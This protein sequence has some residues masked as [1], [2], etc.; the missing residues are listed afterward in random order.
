MIKIHKCGK[1]HLMRSGCTEPMLCI[2]NFYISDRLGSLVGNPVLV[3][4]YMDHLIDYTLNLPIVKP[5]Q[6]DGEL[7]RGAIKDSHKF[8]SFYRK[9]ASDPVRYL[10]YSD[11]IILQ[12]P[13]P[14]PL[15][16]GP[17][18]Q[19]KP[20]VI[21]TRHLDKEPT[22]IPLLSQ[23]KSTLRNNHLG[24]GSRFFT[25]LHRRLKAV[26]LFMHEIAT[27]CPRCERNTR[28]QGA[29]YENQ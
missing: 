12:I 8:I 14:Y 4:P 16:G 1:H 25:F 21:P 9:N 19:L 23:R 26:S 17:K 18:S 24:P 5:L 27:R 6:V 28:T 29:Q 2:Y 3:Q 20:V 13:I 11:G 15:P 7:S 10:R 22:P